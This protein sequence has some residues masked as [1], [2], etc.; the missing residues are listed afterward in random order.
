MQ[1]N[2]LRLKVARIRQVGLTLPR[3]L[4]TFRSLF[5]LFRNLDKFTLERRQ[6]AFHFELFGKAKP[7]F[8]HFGNIAEEL[9]TPNSYIS[10]KITRSKGCKPSSKRRG[11][12][13]YARRGQR[14]DSFGK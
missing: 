13:R 10:H 2:D 9:F 7:C 6:Y 11:C 3:T 1:I 4:D 8:S 14:A 12:G 5:R